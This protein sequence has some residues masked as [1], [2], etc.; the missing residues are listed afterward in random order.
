MS[1]SGSTFINRMIH[2]RVRKFSVGISFVNVFGFKIIKVKYERVFI[3]Y[4]FVD[5]FKTKFDKT[6]KF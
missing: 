2:S 1:T 4:I 5:F 3:R 6:K